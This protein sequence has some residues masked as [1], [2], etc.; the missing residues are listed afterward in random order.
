MPKKKKEIKS[1]EPILTLLGAIFY[2]V[3][4]ENYSHTSSFY[5]VLHFILL[6]VVVILTLDFLVS[7]HV[8]AHR[9]CARDEFRCRNGKCILGKWRCNNKDECGDGSDEKGCRGK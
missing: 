2:F 5:L 9:P 8:P 3:V 7:G 4:N 1:I 6:P